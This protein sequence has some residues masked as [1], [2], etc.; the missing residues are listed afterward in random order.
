[1]DKPCNQ[2]EPISRRPATPSARMRAATSASL[3][4]AAGGDGFA[5]ARAEGIT[6]N[7]DNRPARGPESAG[8]SLS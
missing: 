1:M 5:I 8:Y 7:D 2:G 3:A 4:A 6:W